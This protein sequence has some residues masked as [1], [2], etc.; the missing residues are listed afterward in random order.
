MEYRNYAAKAT[1]QAGE[2]KFETLA[3]M[4][5]EII[6]LKTKMSKADCDVPS[7][8]EDLG[9]KSPPERAT[10]QG[11]TQGKTKDERRSNPKSR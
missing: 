11:G 5:D 9:E 3:Q 1:P 8:L 2:V 10:G 6:E 7:R 4:I